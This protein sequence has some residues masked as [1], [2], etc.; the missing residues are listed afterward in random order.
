MTTH[1][2]DLA[3]FEIDKAKNLV[4]LTK[5]ATAFGKLTGNYL[6]SQTTQEFLEAFKEAYPD[7]PNG[8]TVVQGGSD[9]QGTWAHREIALHFAQWISPKFHVFCIKKLDELFQTGSTTL[10]PQDD[11]SLMAQ[12]LQAAHR[13]IEKQNETIGALLPKAAYA[14]EVLQS[15]SEWTVTT[16]AKELGM[17]A[18]NLNMFLYSLRVQFKNTDGVWVLYAKHQDK[19][20][21]KT[22]THPYAYEANGEIKTDILTVW[23]EKGREFIHSL[24]AK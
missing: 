5:I 23:T 8:I 12:G 22:R 20:Y 21:T 1:N 6:K 13:I 7:I 9:T 16:I 2:F 4:N 11:L 3:I 15:T 24:F 18:A 14:D 17:S 19:G 10:A